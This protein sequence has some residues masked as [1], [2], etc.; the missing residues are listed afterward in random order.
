MQEKIK[1]LPEDVK[2]AIMDYV[3]ATL[4]AA[5]HD[6]MYSYEQGAKDC[7]SLLKR[8]GVLQKITLKI[9]YSEDTEKVVK[10]KSSPQYIFRFYN[11]H[12]NILC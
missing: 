1:D 8:L 7:V 6:C 12:H 10:Y 4:L 2:K 3:E 11:S 5:D 9:F